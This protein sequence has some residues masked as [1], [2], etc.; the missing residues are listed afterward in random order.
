MVAELNA[1]LI[2]LPRFFCKGVIPPSALPKQVSDLH[3]KILAYLFAVIQRNIY[4]S[5]DPVLSAVR[6]AII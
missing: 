4:V 5:K 3:L 1:P 2:Y 6:H